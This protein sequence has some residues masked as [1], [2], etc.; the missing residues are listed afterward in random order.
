MLYI[1]IHI[2][3]VYVPYTQIHVR[4][5]VAVVVVVVIEVGKSHVYSPLSFCPPLDSCETVEITRV[6]MDILHTPHTHTDTQSVFFSSPVYV[7]LY[8]TYTYRMFF[9]TNIFC[10]IFQ[11]RLL[12]FHAI[13]TKTHRHTKWHALIQEIHT[14][15]SRLY[16]IDIINN[17]KNNGCE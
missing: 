14:S 17:N 6:V 16:E 1:T 10:L 4:T 13:D 9:H 12:P 15:F 8:N 7:L 11:W 3:Y 5:I 2:T